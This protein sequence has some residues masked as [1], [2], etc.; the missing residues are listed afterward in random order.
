MSTVCTS[1]LP[2]PEELGALYLISPSSME[3]IADFRMTASDILRSK[4]P[5]VALILGPCSIHNCDEAIEYAKK[6]KVLQKK[7]ANRFF[8]VMRVFFEKPRTRLGWKG[9]LYDP[10]LDGSNDLC[11]GLKKSRKL[12]VDLADMGVPCAT[13][14][15]DPLVSGY[16]SDLITWGL[17]G[18]RTSASQTHRQLASG[19]SFPV[20]FKNGT[21]GDL[22]PAI[23]G[24]ISSQMPH[25][26]FS[27]NQ[28]GRV[29]GIQT[30]GNRLSH[31]VL[32]G[33][34]LRSNCD[35][36]SVQHA[37]ESLK[38]HHQDLRVVIDCAHGNSGKDPKK[39]A[40]AFSNCLEQISG[41]TKAI[42]G[43][44]L[45]SHLHGG[46][47]AIPENLDQLLHGVSITDPC[48]GWDETEDLVCMS[49]VQN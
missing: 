4:D 21:L 47:Q 29:A 46:N 25:T 28:D 13:E 2:T 10:S 26:H 9:F 23:S 19:L 41:G 36:K 34:D 11:E 17:I 38:V 40:L 14:F 12:L 1:I 44:M 32:R 7:V 6:V 30:P 22:E 8:L 18:A 49:G 24:I 3:S 16:F 48:L 31:L 45:E 39:Q 43:L 15:L 20:G 5:R 42:R 33:S 35:P 27:I 37:I